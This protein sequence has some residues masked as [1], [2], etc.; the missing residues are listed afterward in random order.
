MTHV[1][2]LPLPPRECSPNY[3]PRT[4]IG[5]RIKH[6]KMMQWRDC[7]YLLMRGFPAMTRFPVTMHLEFYCA[8]DRGRNDGLYRPRDQDNALAAFKLAQDAIVK[9]GILPDDSCKHVINGRVNIYRKKEEHGG[10]KCIIVT[11][12]E[13]KE[14]TEHIH[15]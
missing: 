10:R 9:A 7:C 6:A 15:N 14:N 8:Q 11:I 13:P 4:E 3:Q 1:I 5:I 12:E 2:E